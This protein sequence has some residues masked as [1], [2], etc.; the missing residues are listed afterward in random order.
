MVIYFLLDIFFF[1]KYLRYTYS[2][3]LQLIYALAGILSKNWNPQQAT[4]ILVLVLVIFG[5]G[6]MFLTKI[7][8]SIVFS[9]QGN[10]FEIR[11]KRMA[12]KIQQ[13]I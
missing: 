1:E 12:Q 9:I 6:I 8:V 2:P 4:S 11:R 10:N 7:V 5:G 3:Y 13:E